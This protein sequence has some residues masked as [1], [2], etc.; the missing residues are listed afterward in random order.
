ML[1]T[2]LKALRTAKG[3]SQAELA[4][5]LSITQQAVASWESGRTEPSHSMLVR[6]CQEL[7]TSVDYLLG[8]QTATLEGTYLSMAKSLRDQGITPGDLD[9]LLATYRHFI[10]LNEKTDEPG[11]DVRT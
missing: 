2:Q 6:L 11:E 1:Q 3:W 8:T 7:N 9:A 4:G 5:R 10:K